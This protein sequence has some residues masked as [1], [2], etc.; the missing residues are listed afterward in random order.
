[1]GV[2]TKKTCGS[3]DLFALYT[4]L[5]GLWSQLFLNYKMKTCLFHSI[6]PQL[7][8][9]KGRVR[10][11]KRKKKKKR[12]RHV[13]VIQ[14]SKETWCESEDGRDMSLDVALWK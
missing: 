3:L 11:E 2:G 6:I 10:N 9:K 14:T 5:L 8:R 4:E 12:N 13:Q 1:M 7:K